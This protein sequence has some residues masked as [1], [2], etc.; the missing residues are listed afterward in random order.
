LKTIPSRRM[1]VGLVTSLISFN[2]LPAIA[3]MPASLP[4]QSFQV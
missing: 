3:T 2:G 1:N 4:V